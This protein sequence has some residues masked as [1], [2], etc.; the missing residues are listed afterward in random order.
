MFMV[1]L[2]FSWAEMWTARRAVFV[3]GALQVAITLI[4]AAL[5][6]RAV[7]MRWPTAVLAGGAAAMCSTAIALK[8]LQ[9][10]RELARAHGRIATGVLLF[11]D[12]ATLPFLVV[13][14]SGSVTG[15]IEF[16]PA[17]RQLIVATLSL[18][19]LLWLGRPVLRVCLGWIGQRESVDLFLLSA[20]LL[21]LG[22]A[23]TAERL[24]AA[25][26]VGAFLAGV[27]VG[28]S[29]LRHRVSAQLR[30]FRD[31]LV[32]VFFVTVGMQ[33]DP[34]AIAAS[35]LQSFLWLALFVFAKPVL[36]VLAMRV[37]RYKMITSVRAAVVLAHASELT[38]L[39]ITQAMSAALLPSR[40]GQAILIAA[41]LS[42]GLAPLM[43]Q[44]NRAIS[45]RAVRL[46][47][48]VVQRWPQSAA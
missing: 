24:G 44:H 40:D 26:T 41:A 7:G 39:I 27:A 29:D 13:I 31:M 17:L 34:R 42:M 23:Y 15:S 38:L 16:L 33:V 43:I 11:Q 8:Q 22:T 45:V 5:I 14:D 9:E 4:G 37:A 6:A 10:R 1:G 28:E 30:P 3:A 32:G 48:R 18:G 12:I 19:G 2:E 36:A 35:P 20:L 25:P 47:E 21:A 46:I